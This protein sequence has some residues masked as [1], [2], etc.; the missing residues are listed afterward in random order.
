[1]VHL[2]FKEREG[3]LVPSGHQAPLGFR[4][5]MEIR[6]HLVQLVIQDRKEHLEI[7]GNTVYLA[8]QDLKG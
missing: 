6:G 5:E 2:E 1:M 4:V 7:K 3:H 8:Q